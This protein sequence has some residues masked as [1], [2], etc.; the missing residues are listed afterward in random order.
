M[1]KN[2]YTQKH[3]PAL[4]QKTMMDV[5]I[6]TFI[7]AQRFTIPGISVENS[8]VAFL[9]C[10]K[11]SEE[12]LTIVKITQTFFRIQKELAYEGKTT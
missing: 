10:Y 5:I 6:Y 9:N 12:E 8:A 7:T 4:Y 3:I 11:I 1:K 2:V